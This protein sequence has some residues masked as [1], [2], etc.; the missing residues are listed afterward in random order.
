MSKDV[1]NY[2]ESRR[3]ERHVLQR[4]KVLRRRCG[5]VRHLVLM[6][7]AHYPRDTGQGGKFMGRALG[8][9]ACNQNFC[10]RIFAM[11]APDGGAG[12]LI[13]SRGDRAGIEDDD[14]GIS[15]R[16]GAAQSFFR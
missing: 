13:G 9:A 1:A 5:D 10:I 6:G 7:I 4:D 12:V 11:H 14:V 3:R 8:I 16:R 15:G 2:G